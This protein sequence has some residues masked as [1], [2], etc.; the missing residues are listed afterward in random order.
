MNK[1]KILA[2]AM[3]A[4]KRQEMQDRDGVNWLID[5]FINEL[6]NYAKEL[7]LAIDIND[8]EE[9]YLAA[10]K[11]KGACSSMGANDL[12]E[13]CKQLESLGKENS[14]AKASQI[15]EE[16]MSKKIALLIAA[17]EQ[18]KVNYPED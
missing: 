6:P 5:L 14:L 13:F 15:L 3:L 1:T 18:E 9:L 10:H 2:P 7:K 16:E 8:G 17:L 4:S 12:E 11:F